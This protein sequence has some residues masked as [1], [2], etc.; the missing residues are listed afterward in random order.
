VVGFVETIFIFPVVGLKLVD[1]SDG[2]SNEYIFEM[3]LLLPK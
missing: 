2:R 1:M 3:G